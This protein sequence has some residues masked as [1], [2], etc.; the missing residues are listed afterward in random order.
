[1]QLATNAAFLTISR[2]GAAPAMPT[3]AEINETFID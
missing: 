2:L 3:R 1:M